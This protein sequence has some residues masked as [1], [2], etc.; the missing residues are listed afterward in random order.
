MKK[1][2]FEQF[3]EQESLSLE[4]DN[5][6]AAPTLSDPQDSEKSETPKNPEDAIPNSGTQD[7]PFTQPTTTPEYSWLIDQ[8]Q[9]H[10]GKYSYGGLFYWLF[11]DQ[12][13]IGRK[14]SKKR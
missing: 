12:V 5:V 2:L 9:K 8:L 14:P 11:N 13:T 7:P 4:A 10:N 3:L 1:T 6:P